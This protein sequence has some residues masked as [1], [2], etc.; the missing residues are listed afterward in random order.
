MVGA[1][2]VGPVTLLHTYVLGQRPQHQQPLITADHAI[3]Y[4]SLST[5]PVRQSVGQE[6]GSLRT[7]TRRR[8]LGTDTTKGSPPGG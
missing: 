8:Q 7:P 1:L 6:A 4:V 5:V 3:A 2:M